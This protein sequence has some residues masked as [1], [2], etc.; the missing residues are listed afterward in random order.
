MHLADGEAGRKEQEDN[1]FSKGLIWFE[2]HVDSK[3]HA[4]SSRVKQNPVLPDLDFLFTRGRI[5]HWSWSPTDSRE[6]FM[7][8]SVRIDHACG[9]SDC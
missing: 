8:L 4:I 6:M 3:I 9:G 5:V 2:I 7:F 1:Q